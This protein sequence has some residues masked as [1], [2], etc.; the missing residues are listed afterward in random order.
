MTLRTLEIAPGVDAE[1]VGGEMSA[2][3]LYWFLD[4][5]SVGAPPGHAA[6]EARRGHTFGSSDET[7]DELRFD[8]ETRQ[9]ASAFLTVPERAGSWKE[10]AYLA[11]VPNVLSGALRLVAGEPFVLEPT[12]LR[13]FSADGSALVCLL[14]RAVDSRPNERLEVVAGLSL[15]CAEG[16]YC[17]WMLVDPVARLRRPEEDSSEPPAEAAVAR[18]VPLLR[19]LFDLVN[20]D[21][22]DDLFDADPELR[23][24]LVSLSADV[25]RE[26]ESAPL[27]ALGAK[28]DDLLDRWF[29]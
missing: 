5:L 17:G 12:D 14:E 19:R 13:V 27:R 2:L 8:T 18:V 26:M 15:L 4:T 9:L 16:V 25:A 28:V 10:W 24:R 20:D 1:V 22:M 29:E 21:T 11:S 6:H 3:P 7:G 23:Q